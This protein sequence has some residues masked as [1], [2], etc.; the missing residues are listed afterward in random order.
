MRR[1]LKPLA[2]ACL[3]LAAAACEGTW[4]TASSPSPVRAI[5]AALMHTGK[6]LLIAGSGNDRAFT[7]N[8][9]GVTCRIY[10]ENG[11]LVV[12]DALGVVDNNGVSGLHSVYYDL[13]PAN[14]NLPAGNYTGDLRVALADEA[15]VEHFR[16][17]ILPATS[18]LDR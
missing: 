8:A 18:K 6:V 16:F 11:N 13:N 12:N 3:V 9:N 4:T 15:P 5:H 14:S 7:V 1:I 2:V 17:R 10:N